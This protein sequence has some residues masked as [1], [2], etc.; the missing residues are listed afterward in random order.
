ML[1]KA[2]DSLSVGD[3]ATRR[4]RMQQTWTLMPF[5]CVIGSVCPASYVRGPR[6]AFGLHPGAPLPHLSHLTS[7]WPFRFCSWHACS[8]EEG[9]PTIASA[10]RFENE[11]RVILCTDFCEVYAKQ[12]VHTFVPGACCANGMLSP[13]VMPCGRGDE[14]PALQRLVRCQQH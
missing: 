7:A 14:F 11:A 3:A 8:R 4:V 6:F 2:A 13:C 9:A 5:A 10:S 12:D 1:A